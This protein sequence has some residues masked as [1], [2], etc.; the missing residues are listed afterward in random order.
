MKKV[1]KRSLILLFIALIFIVIN[2]TKVNAQ[3]TYQVKVSGKYDYTKAYE[4]LNLINQERS[5]K[6]LSFLTMN[7]SLLDKSMLRAAETS[8]YWDHK[9]PN[10]SRFYTLYNMSAIMGENIAYGSSSASAIVKQWM[11]SSSH[12]AN[13]LDS[14]YNSTGI[15]VYYDSSLGKY[16]WVQTFCSKKTDN[17]KRGGV[18]SANPTITCSASQ[19]NLSVEKNNYDLDVGKTANLTFYNTYVEGSLR[20]KVKVYPTNLTINSEN[21]NVATANASGKI[22]AIGGGSTTLKVNAGNKT[23]SIST[24]VNGPIH[25]EKK[26]EKVETAKTSTTKTTKVVKAKTINKTTIT[27][28]TTTKTTN[29]SASARA[30]ETTQPTEAVQEEKSRTLTEIIATN[31]QKHLKKMKKLKEP[32]Y[33]S[34]KLAKNNKTYNSVLLADL[35]ESKKKSYSY[36]LAKSSKEDIG[37]KLI[38]YIQG[39]EPKK[40]VIE[41]QNKTQQTAI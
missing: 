17:K 2:S 6:K 34:V 15:G 39:I 37:S 12:R 22:T 9:R 10:G 5:K 30:K 31:L 27:P 16:F 25:V 35:K 14:D 28:T 32:Y 24:K 29:R 40:I 23:I 3:S 13:I 36:K 7:A 4:I 11:N 1:V 20:I 18:V 19:I 38:S 33:N 21:K 26:K 41:F 8:V